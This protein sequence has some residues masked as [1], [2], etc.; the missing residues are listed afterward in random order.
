[1]Q[2][3]GVMQR[4]S[5][6]AVHDMEEIVEAVSKYFKVKK[7]EIL[8]NKHQEQRKSKYLPKRCIKSET[9]MLKNPAK[10]IK[11]YSD[12]HDNTPLIPPLIRGE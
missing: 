11:F 8:E 6:R 2:Q 9:N 10:A 5:L 12:T 3:E 1:L 7:E 4:R